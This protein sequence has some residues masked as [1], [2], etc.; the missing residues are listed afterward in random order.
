MV[1]NGSKGFLLT[2]NFYNIPNKA[3]LLYPNKRKLEGKSSVHLEETT[4]KQQE[5]KTT[6]QKVTQ[7][8]R[9]K[10]LHANLG[11]PG[12]DSI[13]ATTKHLHYII[14]GELEICK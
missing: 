11:H 10:E 9:I 8:I 4:V 5:K 13:R 14:K 2:T 3:A 1:N 12:E 6:K 7:K